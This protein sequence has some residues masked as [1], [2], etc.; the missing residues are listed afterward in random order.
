MIFNFYQNESFNPCVAKSIASFATRCT[1]STATE[2]SVLEEFKIANEIIADIKQLAMDYPEE[3]DHFIDAIERL[4]SLKE[5]RVDQLTLEFLKV[6][7]EYLDPNSDDLTHT[8]IDEEAKLRYMV[9]A[10]TS[11]N[12][13]RRKVEFEQEKGIVR[14]ELTKEQCTDDAGVR[15][16]YSN[17]DTHDFLMPEQLD[18][19]PLDLPPEPIVEEP[20]AETEEG[21]TVSDRAPSA[22]SPSHITG[23][24]QKGQ[25]DNVNDFDEE[26]KREK[27]GLDGKA[28]V[29]GVWHIDFLTAP[30]GPK[31]QG[32][33][34]I[35][36][37]YSDE[38]TKTE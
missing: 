4:N 17:D 35:K 21:E 13:R 7:Q 5:K 9:W 3:R 6:P 34:T 10:N 25:L 37:E 26:D 1:E 8:F 33:W 11:K 23:A 32:S 24:S 14:V 22:K 18:P 30:E 16:Y 29:G 36:R 28:G 2:S 31:Q 19:S 15:V 20:K 38:L 12:T 27:I